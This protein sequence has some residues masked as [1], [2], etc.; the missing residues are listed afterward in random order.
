MRRG[1]EGA[2]DRLVALT[3]VLRRIGVQLWHIANASACA[4]AAWLRG[5]ANAVEAVAQSALELANEFGEPWRIGQ[6]AMWLERAGRPWRGPLRS[7]AHP[8]TLE[9]AGAWREAADEW[10]LLGCPYDR[11]LA[12]LAGDEAALREAVEIFDTLGA[13]PAAEL[14]RRRLR[15]LGARGVRRGH[16]Q[17]ARRDPH[18]LT[19]RER[20]IHDLLVRGMSNEDIALRLHRST[21]TIEHHVSAI[22]AKLG[23]ASRA[24][25]IAKTNDTGR[26]EK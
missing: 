14:G 10:R 18:G 11:A 6:L 17:H 7:T 3:D 25:A 21:R 9:L 13:R 15:A 22:L 12:L 16:Y 24:G 23:V 8:Y 5:D 1:D 26:A 4:E 2:E 20:E 19:R